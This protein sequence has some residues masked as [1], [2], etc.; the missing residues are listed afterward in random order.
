MERKISQKMQKNFFTHLKNEEK[1]LAT[2]EKYSRDVKTF[3]TFVGDASIDKELMLSYK[4]Y[5][6]SNYEITSANSMIAAINELLRF[7]GWNDLT[8]R[9]YKIQSSVYCPEEKE[10]TKDEYLRLI[11]AADKRKSKQLSLIL[12]TVCSTGI[13]VSELK[14]ITVSAVFRGEVT[15]SCKGKVRRIFIVPE[16]QKKLSDF[17]LDEEIYEGCVFVSKTG[18]PLDRTRVWKYMKDL[19]DEAGVSSSK[20]YPHNLRHLFARTFYA[21]EKDIVTLADILGHSS[22]NTT[23]IYTVTTGEEHRRKMSEM[24]LVT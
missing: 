15:V 12:Q 19:C 20:V 17:L 24:S 2:L 23:R 8:L 13:R 11:G 18:N 3:M 22:I 1:S 10:L 7:L 5:L 16:L 21:K 4:E 6:G 9:R 14:Y